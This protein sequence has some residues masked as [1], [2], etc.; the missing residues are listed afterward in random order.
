M[1]KY[2][3]VVDIIPNKEIIVEVQVQRSVPAGSVIVAH[4]WS[5][6]R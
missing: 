6:K 3:K 4:S 2:E 5:L 1:K